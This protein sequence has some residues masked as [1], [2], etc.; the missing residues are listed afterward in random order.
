MKTYEIN[1]YIRFAQE[2]LLQKSTNV[3]LT[4]D[5][6]LFYILDGNGSI[7]TKNSQLEWYNINR[8]DKH[9]KI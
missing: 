1:A 6:R 8:V 5:H 7:E 3:T 9:Q 2:I 4:Y